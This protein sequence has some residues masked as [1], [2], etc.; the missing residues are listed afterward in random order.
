MPE[1]TSADREFMQRAL[2]LA[3]EGI[4]MTSPNP[5]VGAVVVKKGKILGQGYHRQVGLPHAEVEALKDVRDAE[6][7][8]A[9]MYVTLE[10]CN[11]KGRTA[12]CTE[13]LIAKK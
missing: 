4:G 1:F 3:R 5:M 6:A 11:H 12:P 9:T 7:A 13:L 10:P 2:A 8:G